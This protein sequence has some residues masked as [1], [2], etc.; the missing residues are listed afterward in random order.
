MRYIGVDFGTT[1]SSVCFTQ[2]N[3]AREQFEDPQPVRFGS[4][5][6]LRS[7]LLLDD[8][9]EVLASGAAVYDHPGYLQHPE[10]VHQEFKL[11]LGEDPEAERHTTLL[12]AQLRAG[13]ERVLNLASLA[14]EGAFRTAIGAPAH[15]VSLE[16][17]RAD[18]VCEAARAAGFPS[19]DIVAEPV[20]AMLYHAFLGDIRFEQRV[21]RWL[22][23]DFGG[24]TTDLAIV[25]TAPGGEQPRVLSTHGRPYGGKDFDQLLLEDYVVPRFWDGSPPDPL[26]RLELLVWVRQFKEQFSERVNRGQTE[27]SARAAMDGLSGRVRLT[28]EE[29]E[30]D[31]LAGPLIDRFAGI[32]RDGFVRSGLALQDIDRAIL[33]GGSARWYFVRE[34]IESFFQRHR[35][36]MSANPELTIAKGLALALTGFKVP[37]LAPEDGSRLPAVVEEESLSAVPAGDDIPLHSV[38]D[39]RQLDLRSCRKEA[40]KR[41]HIYAGIGTGFALLVSPL[42][43]VSQIPL[44]AAETHLFTQIGRIYGYSLSREQVVT[45]IGSVIAGGTLLKVGVMEAATFVPGAGWVLKAGVAGTAIEGLGEVAI[46]YFEGRRRR[47]LGEPEDA[48]L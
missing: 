48:D 39:A 20:A 5:P 1:N 8:R 10:R 28:R 19:V 23:L 12:C 43:G 25:E 47:E 18:R 35:V 24:G 40:R 45:V 11:R 34:A 36:I 7:L 26:A 14:K 31:A 46:R 6:L 15:W 16:T 30:S 4:D 38:V 32:L 21:Q 2:Y 13:L 9:A 17:H 41:T 33:T 42:P 3:P 37:E 22:V 44:S 29:F 27:Y